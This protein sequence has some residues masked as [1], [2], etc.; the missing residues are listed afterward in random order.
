[1][2]AFA[3]ML[4]SAAEKAGMKVPPNADE[5][6]RDEFPHFNVFCAVQLGASMPYPGCHWDNAKLIADLSDDEIK[7]I[8][9]TELVDRG[10]AVGST[11]L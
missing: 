8:T 1:M 9:H 4:M 6:D 2:I 3:G 11:I 10:L 7:T 5:F